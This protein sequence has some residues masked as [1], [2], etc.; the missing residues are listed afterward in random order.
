[1]TNSFDRLMISRRNFLTYT[2]MAGMG[3]VAA[4]CAPA[5]TTPAPAPAAKGGVTPAT[6]RVATIAAVLENA[7][8]M[9]GVDQGYFEEFGITYEVTGLASGN[10]VTSAVQAGEADFAD[11]GAGT[12]LA[13]IEKGAGLRMIGTSRPGLNFVIY[14]QKEI[15]SL[16]DLEGK[17]VGAASPGSFLQLLFLALFEKHGVDA[18][19]VEFVNIGASP[20][21]F[22]AVVAGTVAAGPAAVTFLPTAEREGLNAL[23][24]T[25]EELPDYVRVGFYATTGSISNKGDEIARAMAGYVKASRYVITP[26]SKDQWIK[27]AMDEL[28]ANQEQAEFAWNFQSNNPILAQNLEISATQT[29]YMQSLNIIAG[30]QTKIL[31]FEEVADVS[32][33][34]RALELAGTV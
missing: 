5:A 10:L 16:K 4:A 19:K 7:N 3:A 12:V 24:N 18:D 31:P 32:L 1:M 2:G 9:V 34:K 23:V 8:W 20:N 27:K 33:Q 29:D 26:G 11:A 13:A 28:G 22:K 17:Q 21:V 15:T 14:A 30:S 6:V 25:W